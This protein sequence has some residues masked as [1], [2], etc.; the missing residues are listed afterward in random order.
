[1]KEVKYL[2]KYKEELSSQSQFSIF[3]MYQIIQNWH[4]DSKQCH[5]K[6]YPIFNWNCQTDFKI[7]LKYQAHRKAKQI[8]NRR[9]KLGKQTTFLKM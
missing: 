5:P 1:M 4:I 7:H 9:T 3:L 6:F 8:W 2:N